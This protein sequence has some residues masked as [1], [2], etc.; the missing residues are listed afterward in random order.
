MYSI[1]TYT[2]LDEY[3]LKEVDN[4]EI[5]CECDKYGNCK[6][7]LENKNIKQIYKLNESKKKYRAHINELIEVYFVCV[8]CK[9]VYKLSYICNSNFNE[10]LTIE[11]LDTNGELNLII[12]AKLEEVSGDIIALT[13]E[14]FF[15]SY[16]YDKDDLISIDNIYIK[17]KPNNNNNNFFEE[18]SYIFYNALL[19]YELFKIK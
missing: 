8:N 2:E 13:N 10:E 16:D 6:I 4:P 14:I 12:D 7:L 11:N 1:S 17:V 19:T 15:N 5:L 3:L 9:K 18:Y